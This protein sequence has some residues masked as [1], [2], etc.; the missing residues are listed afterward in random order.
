MTT[1]DQPGLW[2]GLR[3]ED[4]RA[5]LRFLVAGLGF[6]EQL[7]VPP[8]GDRDVPHAELLWPAGGGVML[9]SAGGG[10]PAFDAAGPASI[11]L[12]SDD[13]DAVLERAVRAG[14][15]VV[16]P[17]REES[18]GSREFTVRDPEG[19]L[20]SVGTYRGTPAS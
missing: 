6:V 14:A 9:G 2:P 10:E 5:A 7:V 17:L 18:Y 16:R 20:W 8:D 15:E 11:Y 13:P 19:N 12:V 4:A 3:Y 1:S